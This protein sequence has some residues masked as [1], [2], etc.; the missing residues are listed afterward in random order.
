MSWEKFLKA[1]SLMEDLKDVL[2]VWE[3]KDYP[4][5]EKRWKAYASDIE[6]LVFKWT[7][8]EKDIYDNVEWKSL[9]AIT[10]TTAGLES[11]PRYSRRKKKEGD[12]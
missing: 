1:E 8:D 9:G 7:K 5:D 4:S 3:K 10:S 2:S 12:E 11:K 6:A